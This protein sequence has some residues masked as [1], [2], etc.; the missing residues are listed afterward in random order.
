MSKED[1]LNRKLHRQMDELEALQ[2]IHKKELSKKET[3]K[4]VKKVAKYHKSFL[5]AVKDLDRDPKT[6]YNSEGENS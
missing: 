4:E 2:K 3:W 6:Y 5:Y 1:Y